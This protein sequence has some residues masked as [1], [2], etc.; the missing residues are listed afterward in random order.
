MNEKVKK[1]KEWQGFVPLG[2][3]FVAA[4]TSMFA[5]F[6]YNKLV[7][8]QGIEW[9]NWI[10]FILLA[11][12]I[13]CSVI[14]LLLSAT[15]HSEQ[16]VSYFQLSISLIPIYFFYNLVKL[17]LNL[18]FN[19]QSE[20]VSIFLDRVYTSPIDKTILSVLGIIIIVSII[21]KI[22]KASKVN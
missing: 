14:A 18:V 17:L 5:W 8:G 12:V 9:Y 6:R 21:K 20:K 2:A 16:A 11:G 10:S 19:F 3:L 22:L 4:A 1:S 7:E 13:G 15:K